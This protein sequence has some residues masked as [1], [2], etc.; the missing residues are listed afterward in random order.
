MKFFY[1]RLTTAFL[2]SL[3]F[4]TPGAVLYVDL[5][6]TNPVPP[7]AGWSTAATNI[8]D[9]VDAATDGDEVLV[10]NG[11]YQT[12]GR[13]V[14]MPDFGPILTNRV[15]LTNLLTVTSVNGPAVTFIV[16]NQV[17]GTINDYGAVR[18]VCLDGGATLSGFTITNGATGPGGSDGMWESWGGGLNCPSG[19]GIVSNCVIV[20]NSAGDWGG[21]AVGGTFYNCQFIGNQS[22]W[23][24]G[25]IIGGAANNC[26]FELNSASVG[27]GAAGSTLTDCTL[28]RNSASYGGGADYSVLNNCA[29]SGNTSTGSGGGAGNSTLNNCILTGN[30]AYYGGGADSSALNNCALAGNSVLFNGGAAENCTLNNCTLVFNSAI[31]TGGGV[32]ASTLNNCIVYYNSAPGGT[33]YSNGT[34]NYCCTTPLPDSGTNNITADPQLADTTHIRAGSPCIGAGSTNYSTGVDLDGEPWLNPPS[35][36]CDEYYAGPAVGALSVAIQAD[37]TNVLVGVAVGFAELIDGQTTASFWDF[38][39]GTAVSNQ[40]SV[41]HSWTAPGN[42]PV[43]LTAYNDSNPGGISATAMV[44]VTTQQV[45]YVDASSTNPV[46]PF[47]TWGTAAANIQDAVDA[48]VVGGTVLVTNGIYQAGGRV[49]YG[50]LTNR[51]AVT[52]PLTVQS[53]NGP[54]VTVIQGYQD[55]IVTNSDDALRCVYLAQKSSLIG[56]TLTQGAT[57]SS[58]DEDVEQSGGGVWCESTSV[59]VSDCVLTGN[60]AYYQGGGVRSG[61]LINCLLDNNTADNSGGGSENS[62]LNNCILTGNSASNGGGADSSTLNNCTLTDNDAAGYGGGTENSALNNCTLTANSAGVNGGAVDASTLNNCALTANSA[63]NNGGGSENSTLNNCTLTANSAAGGGGADNCALNNCIVYYNTADSQP[64]YS[65]GT[66]NFCCTPPLPTSG[67]NNITAEPQLMDTAHISAYSPCIGAGSTN[68]ATGV[69]IDGELWLNPPSIGCDEYYPGPITGALSVAIQA[70]HTNVAPGFAVNFTGLIYGHAAASFWDFGDGTVVSNR[71]ALA[72]GWTSSGVYNVTLTAFNDSNPGGVSATMTLYVVEGTNYVSLDSANPVSPYLS[73]DTAATN[74]QDAVDAAVPG[75]TV[76]VGNG[77]YQT[78]GSVANGSQSNRVAVTKPLVLRSVNGPVVTTIQGNPV[79]GDTAVRCVYLTNNTMLIGF[80]LTQGAT[81]DNQAGGGVYCESASATV[82]NCVLNGNSGVAAGGGAFGGTL[83]NCVLCSNTVAW[84]GSGGGAS[85]G[86]LNNCL[87]Y[88][89]SAGYGGGGADT[90]T[91][92]N[93]TIINNSSG[94][95]NGGADASTLNNCIVYYNNG[96]NYGNSTL[97]YCCTTP[98]PGGIGNIT[99][100]PAFVDPSNGDFHLQSNS[101]CINVGN[102]AYVNEAT[103]LDGNPRIVGGRV[104]IGA[105]EF[106]TTGPLTPSIQFDY[107]NV[108]AGYAVNFRLSIPSGQFATGCVWDFGDGT[109]LSNQFS[110]SHSW[111]STGDY[112]VVLTAFNDSNPGGVSATVVIH[113]ANP[114]VYF[115]DAA[116]TNPMPPYLSW[117][118]A[119]TNIQDAVDAV[120]V[121]GALVLVTNGLYQSGNRVSSDGAT[122]RVNVAMPLTLRSVNGAAFTTIDGG[123][124]TRCVCLTNLVT[125]DGFTLT[126]GFAP[127]NGGGVMCQSTNVVANCILTGNRAGNQGGGAYGAALVNCALN[128]NSTL[129]WNSSGGGAAFCTLNNCSVNS[130]SVP[131]PDHG[132]GLINC[133]AAN[134]SLI[135]NTAEYGG[136]A[137][138]CA[139]D[140]CVIGTNS[141][142]GTGGAESSTLNNCLLSG[143]SG[144]FGGGVSGSTLNQCVL[145]GNTAFYGGGADASTL[146]NCTLT[147]NLGLNGGGGANN[148]AL[149]NCVLTNNVTYE[150]GGGVSSCIATNCLM[151]NNTAWNNN[152]GGADS[153]TLVNCTLV[154]NTAEYGTGGGANACTLDN[155]IVYYN[156]VVYGGSPAMANYSGSPLNYC[157]TTPAPGGVGNI[158]NEPLFMNWTNGDC[159]LQTNSPCINSGNNVYVS[160]TNDLDGNPRIVGGTV[161]IGAYEYQTPTSIISYAWLQQYGFPTDGSADYADYD[162][163]GM[164]NWQKWI[165]GLNPTNPASVLVMLTPVSTNNPPGLVVS[166]QS[167]SGITYF[168]Q[169]STNLAAQPAFSTIQSNIVGQAGTTSYTDTTA[170]NGGS[171][172]YRVGVQ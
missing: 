78:G 80:T 118:T 105:Y 66:L 85:D 12:G 60:S 29:L 132:G 49:V 71:F 63:A 172:F 100:D 124:V 75:M 37:Y 149:N 128:G 121:P 83:N 30:S 51:V 170:T 62:T 55:P 82:S 64:N 77:V 25:G 27:G 103:D 165:A 2:A 18:C 133:Q 163:T 42:Y 13:P 160:I 58:G 88:A 32:D 153:S 91:L 45:Y 89:N 19:N 73:W 134:C 43:V 92:N 157:C 7:Y 108:S 69:D 143:N 167:V 41:S 125:L 81:P 97:N 3:T 90:A 161:D 131:W 48:A 15:V 53:V 104:D 148:S 9:A 120:A 56:F 24:S 72:H 171:Y 52:I 36:G 50:S 140:N 129:N 40:V 23:Y 142:Y 79:I 135:G 168:L 59:T 14:S 117:D 115:V 146:T 5:N 39:D 22:G 116:G 8:Q 94:F 130:N 76:L 6:S 26:T 138:S 109:V 111:T 98:D 141:A 145:S 155:C 20:G 136:G 152:G 114:P 144:T 169:S 158:T 126:N 65:G 44:Y 147:G 106:H 34:L 33:N 119:A 127:G 156:H 61:V 57:R 84:Y 68:Y 151:I 16:G 96:G 87:L 17:P 137:S 38:G 47:L 4:R 102:N 154:G 95:L 113:V 67:T 101:P 70:D 150:S 159:Y 162:G 21:G 166:W 86:T 10:T 54:A 112:P 74:I 122:N 107:T 99:N 123:G 139:L 93:C 164:N 35:I 110:V 11:V 31:R 46:A 1:L 28:T